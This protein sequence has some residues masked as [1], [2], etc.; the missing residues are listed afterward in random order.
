MRK[1]TSPKTGLLAPKNR[2]FLIA[3]GIAAIIGTY[4]LAGDK[5]KGLFKR[6]TSDQDTPSINPQTQMPAFEPVIISQ[7]I[8]TPGTGTDGLDPD[9]RLRKGVKGNEV[10]RIQIIA[11]YLANLFGKK[12][13]SVEVNGKNYG[14]VNFPL[15]TDGNFG[16]NTHKA[17]I[18]IRGKNYLDVGYTTL[19][20]MRY[21]YAYWSGYYGKDFP[22]SLRSSSRFQRY[23]DAYKTGKIDAQK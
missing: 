9:K 19:D 12:S 18:L 15:Q 3:G 10:K 8:V 22:D 6:D 2:K 4:L 20:R 14:I 17:I 11:N 13:A 23:S 7:P 16:E 5:I 1:R 21:E